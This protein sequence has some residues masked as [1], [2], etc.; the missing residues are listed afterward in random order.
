M[1]AC[2]NINSQICGNKSVVINSD[3]SFQEKN[4]NGNDESDKGENGQDKGRLT[5]GQ[6]A[7]GT[8]RKL[9]SV[10]Q[11]GSTSKDNY[12]LNLQG[13]ENGKENSDYH[14]PSNGA[15]NVPDGHNENNPNLLGLNNALERKKTRSIS[16]VDKSKLSSAVYKDEVNLKVTICTLVEESEG[17]PTRKYNVISTLGEGSYG[18]VYLAENLLTKNK[19][20]M[21]KIKKI[22]ENIIDEMEIKNE[23]EIL[24]QLDHPNIVRILEFYS[25]HKAYYIITDYCQSGELYGQIKHTYDENQLAVLFYQ[26]FSGLLYLHTN[27][28]LHRDLKLENILISEIEKDIKTGK[29][30]FWIKIIDFGTAK[31]FEP[32]KKEKAIVGSSYYIA[33]E[34]LK[35]S[36]NEKCDTWSVGVLL[37]M[38]IVGRAP[39]D[40]EDDDEIIRKIHS[41]KYDKKNK[42][43]L[44][45][46]PE[47]QD[48]VLKLLELNV[49]KRLSASEALAHPWFTK[50][51]AKSLYEN[52]SVDKIR[53]YIGRLS[54]YRIYSKFQQFVLAFI[55]HHLPFNEN[56]KDVLKIFRIFNEKNDGKLTKE[57]LYNG[58]TKYEDKKV[59]IDSINDIFFLLDG[60]SHGFI[61]FEEFLRGCLDS[62]DLFSEENLTYAFNFFDKNGSGKISI[63]KMRVV[64]AESK[65][66]EEMFRNIIAE[67]DVNKDG[68]ID[69]MEFK[70]MMIRHSR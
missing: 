12:H 24:K 15:S 21:K 44:R 9:S 46:S 53:L 56:M 60:A 38:L 61:E 54:T 4:A 70:R 65:G 69:F 57:E 6:K 62:K 5:F 49:K 2:S 45:S 37:Y 63:Q 14:P 1:G 13:F 17:L 58:I 36:Y 66:S 42:K 7:K 31:I 35:K 19:V 55:V 47:V 67:V 16:L 18:T 59:I 32:H 43:L 50:Y 68:E 27:N 39:F 20:A 8:N 25:T 34:V 40:G 11:K 29:N 41:G 30:Y 28:I 3:E 52:I 26:V 33:P 22:K 51:K 64:F 23:I 10:L 48:L